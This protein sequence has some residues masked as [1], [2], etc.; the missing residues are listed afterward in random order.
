VEDGIAVVESLKVG[1]ERG[2]EMVGVIVFGLEIRALNV[3]ADGD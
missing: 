2:V 3:V 1:I